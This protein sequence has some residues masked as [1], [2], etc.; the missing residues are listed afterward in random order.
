MTT[1]PRSI[2]TVADRPEAAPALLAT[3]AA[4]LGLALQLRDGAYHPSALALVGVAL[5]CTLAVVLEVP[6]L[7]LSERASLV[8]LAALA[9]G[10]VAVLA[11]LPVARSLPPDLSRAPLLACLVGAALAIVGIA[12]GPAA[13]RRVAIAVLLAAHLAAGVWILRHAAP[14]TDVF[15]FQRGSLEAFRHGVDPYAIKFRNYYHPN[16]SFYG[17]GLVVRG[18]VQFGYP[19]PPL[20]LY[21]IWPALALGDIRYAHLLALTGGGAAIACA[22]AGRAAPLAAALLLFSPRMGL[23]L[24]MS[25]TEPFTI[26]FLGLTVLCAL[27]APR[28]L[29]LALGLFLATKQYLV[30]AAPLA[31]LLVPEPRLRRTLVLLGQAAVVALAISLPLVLWNVPAFIRSAVTLQ[32]RQPFRND[33]LSAVVPLVRAGLPRGLGII[34]PLVLAPLATLVAMRRCPRTPGGFALGIAFTYLVFLVVN[35]QAFCNYYFFPLAG[36]CAALAAGVDRQS[37]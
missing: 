21:L 9:L 3:A 4:A 12:L 32:F 34:L 27:R 29:P 23:L 7:R 31:S 36:L 19:Y 35:K 22:R 25:W 13:V 24:Q 6:V 37:T 15:N 18:I 1:P 5:I 26:L 2:V 16:E 28:L 10:Q 8:L 20:P 33:A 14:E 30:F 17:P 11:A